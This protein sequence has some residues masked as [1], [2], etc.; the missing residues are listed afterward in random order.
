MVPDCMRQQTPAVLL[1]EVQFT[2][3]KT[4]GIALF[5]YLKNSYDEDL[6]MIVQLLLLLLLQYY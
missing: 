6:E 3:G 2:Y 4:S 5:G 1:M